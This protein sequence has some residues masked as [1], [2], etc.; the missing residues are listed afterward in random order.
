MG[1]ELAAS[2]LLSS[3]EAER[4][5]AS[6]F[7][8][9]FEGGVD[10][11]PADEARFEEQLRIAAQLDHPG[12]ARP[13]A[14][15]AAEPV[16]VSTPP[17][18]G[19]TLTQVCAASPTGRLDP[20]V[21]AA[22]GAE[23]ATILCAAHASGLV[24][25]G[26]SPDTIV[27]RA[28]GAAMILDF[29]LARLITALSASSSKVLR[30]AIECLA[31]EQLGSPNAVGP[32][33]DVFGLGVVL[34]RAMSGKE[35]FGAPSAL[36]ASI[37]LSIGKA[38]PID[39]HGVSIPAPL[40]ALVM[41]M[42]ARDPTERPSMR[43]VA[44]A[45]AAPPAL[46]SGRYADAMRGAVALALPEAA[47][48]PTQQTGATPAPAKAAATPAAATPPDAS[49]L[50]DNAAT[51]PTPFVPPAISPDTAAALGFGAPASRATGG[52]L[53]PARVSPEH[54]AETYDLARPTVRTDGPL[55]SPDEIPDYLRDLTSPM[56]PDPAPP[57][58]DVPAWPTTADVTEAVPKTVVL[59]DPQVAAQASLSRSTPSTPVASS[60][61]APIAEPRAAPSEPATR[62]IPDWVLWVAVGFGAVLVLG[63]TVL[64]AIVLAG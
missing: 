55:V 50:I 6:V 41:S 49:S 2:G 14:W 1:R 53:P 40:S 42:I 5:G 24:H 34:Y 46:P 21:A 23:L 4:D 33:T 37:L 10:A 9:I 8:R 59:P 38:A 15:S 16:H 39:S 57:P 36:A 22:M 12:I 27:L 56:S 30:G 25:A 61:P 3:Y 60:A 17:I 20:D 45:L 19:A 47:A 13:I 31:P 64:L 35:P 63:G 62:G 51:A 18:H 11:S 48:A 29:G 26:L 7:L 28:D 44:T 54:G 43:D 58:T 32:T 52:S